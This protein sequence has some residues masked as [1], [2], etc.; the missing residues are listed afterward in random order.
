MMKD[1]QLKIVSAEK[2]LFDGKVVVVKLPGTEG[3]F[4]ILSQHAALISSLKNGEIVYEVEKGVSQKIT[5]QSGF[6][7]V[8]H[9]VVTVCI[10]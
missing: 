9:N 1:L 4:S 5:I 6:A 7:E 2:I 10:E 3:D 8:N